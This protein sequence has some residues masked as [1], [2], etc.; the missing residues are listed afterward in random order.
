MG[1]QSMNKP[2][3]KTKPSAEAEDAPERLDAAI[4]RDVLRAAETCRER[5]KASPSHHA[6]QLGEILEALG[7]YPHL[8]DSVYRL[9]RSDRRPSKTRPAVKPW[10]GTS[11]PGRTA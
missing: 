6:Y 11:S 1:Q 4:S 9:V 10:T 7:R 2:P 8:I 3:T 5:F